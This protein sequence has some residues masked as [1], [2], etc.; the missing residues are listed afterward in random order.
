[1]AASRTRVAVWLTA[2]SS[3][4]RPISPMKAMSAGTGTSH[5]LDAMATAI[6]RS[7]A[8]SSIL[9]PL[10]TLRKMS[11]SYSL[12]PTRRVST[13]VVSSI[14]LKSMPLAVRRGLG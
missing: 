4:L 12:M 9:R 14:R 6:A 1:L 3:P 11:F 5:A 10:M 2:R 7:A 8:G 13:A